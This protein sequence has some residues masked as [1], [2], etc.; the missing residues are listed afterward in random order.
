MKEFIEKLI[1][2]FERE[3]F[4]VQ[5]KQGIK[6]PS[7][8]DM[9]LETFTVRQIEE[10]INQLAEEYKQPF[11]DHDLMIVESLP[12]L[13]PIKEFEEKAIQRVIRCAKKEYNND[14]CE[15]EINSDESID[16]EYKPL[17][18]EDGFIYVTGHFDYKFCPYCGKKI[19]VV[20]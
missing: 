15:W 9:F 2:K 8:H 13:Y 1:E 20:E 7:T 4:A 10:I 6:N 12:S 5:L 3:A 16:K 18:S 11:N 14:V 17:C 19:K